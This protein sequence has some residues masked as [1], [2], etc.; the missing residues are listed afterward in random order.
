[1]PCPMP[2]QNPSQ[3][4]TREY[5]NGKRKLSLVLTVS[6]IRQAYKPIYSYEQ[7][8]DPENCSAD[9]HHRKFV[10]INEH[11]VRILFRFW[12]LCLLV[13][14]SKDGIPI[15]TSFIMNSLQGSV[16][17]GP[18][19]QLSTLNTYKFFYCCNMLIFKYF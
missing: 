14:G 11:R 16:T 8:P 9:Q 10:S 4:S 3:L 12:K 5:K 6:T 7:R 13:A 19:L 18:A 2:D 1:M 17:A 15:V